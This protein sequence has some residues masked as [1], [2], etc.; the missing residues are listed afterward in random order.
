MVLLRHERCS[1]V[2]RYVRSGANGNVGVWVVEPKPAARR[3][4]YSARCTREHEHYFGRKAPHAVLRVEHVG[5][6]SDADEPSLGELQIVRVALDDADR[7]EPE[8]HSC[9]RQTEDAAEDFE[10]R[11]PS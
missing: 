3:C 6:S 7:I 4:Y 2:V 9:A 8:W 5:R 11:V 10:A 1:E